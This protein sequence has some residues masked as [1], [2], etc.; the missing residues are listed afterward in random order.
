MKDRER[1]RERENERQRQRETDRQTERDRENER[2]RERETERDR[3]RERGGGGNRGLSCYLVR[4]FFCFAEML[5]KSCQKKW[6][7]VM[8][9]SIATVSIPST[10][11][12][13]ARWVPGT[14]HL[15]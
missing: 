7:L 15:T 11:A 5:E 12:F 10:Q 1:E 13:D 2:Q 8:C 3:E 9:D 4:I 6:G 14:G